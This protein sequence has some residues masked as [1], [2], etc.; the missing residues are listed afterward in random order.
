VLHAMIIVQLP[1]L[2]RCFPATRGAVDP[3]SVS[4]FV[5]VRVLRKD[6]IVDTML[7]ESSTQ[8]KQLKILPTRDTRNLQL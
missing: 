3:A 2:G 5:P 7:P 1:M 4:V 8:V 6:I